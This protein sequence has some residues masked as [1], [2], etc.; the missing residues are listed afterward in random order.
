MTAI[1]SR[2][3]DAARRLEPD[4]YAAGDH[5]FAAGRQ[6]VH[7]RRDAGRDRDQSADGADDARYAI[8]RRPRCRRRRRSRR[9][10][11]SSVRIRRSGS[12]RAGHLDRRSSPAPPPIRCSGTPANTARRRRGRPR[13]P[14]SVL[15]RPSPTAC[16]PT[17]RPSPPGRQCRGAGGDDLFAE[18]S[19]RAGELSGAEPA[20]RGQS[21]RPAR[22]ASRSAT[23]RPTSPMRRRR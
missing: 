23:S 13:P 17:S 1:R 8:W 7:H 6:P 9:P 3:A 20:G 12:R 2:S 19:E 18:Q 11:T 16:A 5:G 4:H 10:T 15:R 22:H 14:R 21:R